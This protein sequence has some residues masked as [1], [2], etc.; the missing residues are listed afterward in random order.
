MTPEPDNQT[1]P[2]RGRWRL[3]GLNVESDLPLPCPLAAGRRTDLAIRWL[4]LVPPLFPTPRSSGR[5]WEK[6]DGG[7]VLRY[8]NR[9][10]THL[11]IHLEPDGSAA[12]ISHHSPFDRLDFLSILL[13]PG[14]AAALRLRGTPVLHGGAV[15]VE[16]GAALFLSSS[17]AGKSTLTA[18]L[19]DIGQ[20]LL[21][22]EVTSLTLQKGGIR[23]PPGHALLKLSPQ[24]VAALGKAP[25]A[26]PR[27][28]PGFGFQDEHWLDAKALK[29]GIHDAAAPL[30]IVY[31]LAGRRT[32]LPRPR[33]VPL[34]PA[35][36]SIVLS[37]HFYGQGWL[38]PP[39]EEALRLGV[40]I[41][42]A[43]PIRQVWLPEGLGTVHDAA[44][45]LVDDALVGPG[46]V[47]S[48]GRR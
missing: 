13:G 37:R 5:T 15:V 40:R 23:V 14:L 3:H 7:W 21:S 47:R 44:R 39:P 18:A 48:G 10:G 9:D 46:A 31:L 19:V 34:A 12:S 16:G 36:A 26:L 22:D 2:E 27:V 25:A 6:A 28:A 24:A 17:G 32:G 43:A 4:G 38:S 8:L 33:I 35:A 29:G 1:P 41:A 42:D 20:P 45:A 11:A 30:R